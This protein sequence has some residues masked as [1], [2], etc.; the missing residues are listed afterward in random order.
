MAAARQNQGLRAVLLGR[1]RDSKGGSSTTGK[2]QPMAKCVI[3]FSFDLLGGYLRRLFGDF[4]SAAVANHGN[5]RS[6]ALK[7]CVFIGGPF[8]DCFGAFAWFKQLSVGRI[9]HR[10]RPERNDRG[11]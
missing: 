7:S 8:M 2:M 10:A 1:E 5:V 3:F 4:G 9:A 6:K 11:P